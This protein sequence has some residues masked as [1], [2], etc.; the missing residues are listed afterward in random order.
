VTPLPAHRGK[1]G[2]LKGCVLAEKVTTKNQKAALR[3]CEYLVDKEGASFPD[4][5][6][7]YWAATFSQTVGPWM[8]VV[9]IMED[10]SAKEDLK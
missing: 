10:S 1:D 8:S 2:I 7:W 4:V 6:T 9:E 5:S 3:V